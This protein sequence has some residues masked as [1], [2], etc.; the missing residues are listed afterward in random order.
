MN[1]SERSIAYLFMIIY[2]ILYFNSMYKFTMSFYNI[3]KNS[4]ID[5]SDIMILEIIATSVFGILYLIYGVLYST[6]FYVPGN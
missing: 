1:R 3:M 5:E 4:L 6:T 2:Y